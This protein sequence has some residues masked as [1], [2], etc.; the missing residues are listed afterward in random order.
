MLM[1]HALA[2]PFSKVYTGAKRTVARIAD[3]F[4]FNAKFVGLVAA[5]L[6]CMLLCARLLHRLPRLGQNHPGNSNL[7]V[8]C[9]S[10]SEFNRLISQ[11]TVCPVGCAVSCLRR[12]APLFTPP[13][14]PVLACPCV[15]C[16]FCSSSL[17]SLAGGFCGLLEGR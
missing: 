1:V 13:P 11:G 14:G 9:S 16:R 5:L 4:R 3:R 2:P 8:L 7:V 12:V 6:V 15:L 17:G 10:H